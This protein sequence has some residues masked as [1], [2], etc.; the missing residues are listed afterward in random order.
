VKAGEPGAELRIERGADLAAGS[1][2]DTAPG[3]VL[4]LLRSAVVLRAG[5]LDERLDRSRFALLP[6]GARY[7]LVAATTAP[8]VMTVLLLDGAWKRAEREYRPHL[9]LATAARVTASPRIFARTRWVDEL[10]HRYLFERE[11]C[12]KHASQAAAFL[13]TE[14]AKEVYF[15]G[16]EQLEG[17]ARASLVHDEGDIARRALAWMDER[18]FEPFSLQ[19]LAHHCHTSESTLLRSFRRETGATPAAYLREKRLDEAHL[20]LLGGRWSVGEIAQRVGYT[21]LA[22]FTEAFGRRFGVPPSEARAAQPTQPLLPPHGQPP[23]RR[24]RAR[25]HRRRSA[26]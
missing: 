19:D 18:L 5:A 20:L 9:D 17:Q 11:T 25:G 14:L 8:E 21:N 23:K 7:R 12:C 22:A 15:L 16:K 1:R 6:A 10:A 2:V 4:P 26:T 24:A 13:E 3:L